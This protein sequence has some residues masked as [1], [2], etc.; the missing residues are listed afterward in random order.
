MYWIGDVY[1]G[2][3]ISNMDRIG[4]GWMGC[5]FKLIGRRM[6]LVFILGNRG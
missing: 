2:W 4:W 1:Y 6:D 3:D 5:F